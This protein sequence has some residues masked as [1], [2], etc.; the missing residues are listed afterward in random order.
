MSKPIRVLVADYN[1]ESAAH[2]SEF[3]NQQAGICVVSTVRDGQGVLHQCTE[4]LPDVVV[5]D[6]HL[7]GLE[8]D[9]VKTIKAGN[10]QNRNIKFLAI[11]GQADDRY[12]VEAVKAGATG[13]VSVNKPAGYAGIVSAIH[14]IAN[15]EV[16][17]DSML[18]SHILQEFS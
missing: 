4:T 5:I 2:L 7:P 16:V 1:P 17:L 13:Y 6:L 11:S 10:L 8:L 12:A 18:A 9:S 14:Q 15:G 3:L